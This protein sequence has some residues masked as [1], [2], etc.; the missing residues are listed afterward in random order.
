M[1]AL[2]ELWVRTFSAVSWRVIVVYLALW[3]AY[4]GLFVAQQ[5]AALGV[6][7]VEVPLARLVIEVSTEAALWALLSPLIVVAVRRDRVGWPVLRVALV[8]VVLEQIAWAWLQRQFPWRSP[9][10]RFV[11]DLVSSVTQSFAFAV[12]LVFVIVAVCLGRSYRDEARRRE[13]E[14]AQ[15]AVE[16]GAARLDAL[17]AQLQPHFLFNALST[18]SSVVHDDTPRA[19]RLIADLGVLLGRSLADEPSATVSVRGELDLLARYVAIQTA[20]F[21]DRLAVIAPTVAALGPLTEARVPPF[22]LQPLVENAIRHNLEIH[23]AP[24][25]VLVSLE[26]AA[27]ELVVEVCDDGVGFPETGQRV[28]PA[29]SGVGLRNL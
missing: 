11:D 24:L 22:T 10:P 21:G 8:V 25:Q 5:V 3:V 14:A 4:A 7:G 2:G 28:A 19:E 26:R 13:R 29:S 9:A 15:L 12:I 23:A 16:T 27:D 18:I 1:A 6:H 20:R 17:T